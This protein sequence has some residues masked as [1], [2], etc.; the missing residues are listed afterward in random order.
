MKIKLIIPVFLLLYSGISYGVE[1]L[2]AD[3]AEVFPSYVKWYSECHLA[4]PAVAEPNYVD[5]T[6][7][8]FQKY[9][10]AYRERNFFSHKGITGHAHRNLL[11]K[12]V[13]KGYG[14]KYLQTDVYKGNLFAH[15][16][17]RFYRPN[18][19]FTDLYYITGGEREQLFYALHS[20]RLTDDL[21]MSFK[22]Q[23][24]RSPSIYSRI[25][26]N[27]A[28]FYGSLDYLSDN[29]RYQALGSFVWNRMENQE[30]GGLR[31]HET[32]EE[33]EARDSVKLYN[34]EGRYRETAINVHQYYQ[35][36]FY[37]NNNN[38]NNNDDNNN[39]FINL[40]RIYHNSSYNRRSF[41][42]DENAP[43]YP[44]F[45]EYP[46]NDS[47]KTYDS[48]IVHNIS[49]RI[50]YSNYR[51]DQGVS[52]F[53]FFFN[54]Y[55]QHDY[56]NIRHPDD[57][58]HD[59]NQF[60]P[61]VRVYSDKRRLFSFDGFFNYTLGGYND[62][63]VSAGISGQ[64]GKQGKSRHRLEI[65]ASYNL[66]EAPYMMN[67]YFGNYVRW[68]NDFDKTGISS[69]GVI[70]ENRWLSIDLNAYFIDNWQYFDNEAL[71]RQAEEYFTVFSA[72][73]RSNLKAGVFG[74][75]NHIVYQFLSDDN[76]EQF[77]QLVSYHSVYADLVLFDKALYMRAGLD[78]S[79][80][81][82]YYAQAY[83]P[84]FKQ[85]YVQN[86][87]K[88]PDYIFL[89]AFINAKIKRARLFVKWQNLGSLIWGQPPIYTI[90]FYPHLEAQIRF[91]IS[92]MFYD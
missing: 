92:W 11:F 10:F 90:P 30:S 91:G 57:L 86:E 83:M 22:Y 38:N 82:S 21:V 85:F 61:G 49:N 41:I 23:L 78:A 79:Y 88:N 74:F 32:F 19:V 9:D 14:F 12:P 80:H 44:Y 54:I 25:K 48:T 87:Y 31:D 62:Q 43:P 37:V 42:F 50:G 17:I 70:Y 60:T 52:G 76:Y 8:G 53:P 47:L 20:Q 64:T 3:T 69:A 39:K 6:L 24:T 45:P 84:V 28:N 27:N 75:D 2:E 36:G 89:D 7:K 58:Q 51:T 34:A 1:L 56:F 55:L 26:S 13:S 18:Y 72:G 66:M 4:N 73:L 67:N 59:F 46:K 68:N 15:E 5:T 16:K 63:D 35:L 65:R 81:S 71:P 29:K 40:G 33:Q 77:P